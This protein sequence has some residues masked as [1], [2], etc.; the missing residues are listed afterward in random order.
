[1]HSFLPL[2]ILIGLSPLLLLEGMKLWAL[3]HFQFFPIAVA[4]CLW[5]LFG[6]RSPVAVT[7]SADSSA[8][9]E[10]GI[11]LT[12]Y[13]WWAGTLCIVAGGLAGIT[14][15]WIFSPLMAHGA[16]IAV[17][18]G[19]CLHHLT[20][21]S[22]WRIAGIF[23]LLILCVPLP[24]GYDA[25][26]IQTLQSASSVA[27]GN[28]LD[29][30][31]VIHLREG[32]VIELASKRLFVEE[33]CSGVDSLYALAAVALAM[34]IYQRT[35]L[36]ASLCTMMTVPFWATMGNLFRLVTIAIGVEKWSVD[37][38][39]GTPHLILGL[40][41]FL[42]VS[43][44]HLSTASAFSLLFPPSRNGEAEKSL[45]YPCDL[46]SLF[47][48]S[49]LARSISLVLVPMLG[50]GCVLLGLLAWTVLPW[51]FPDVAPSWFMSRELADSLPGRTALP[52]D[53]SN[54]IAVSYNEE[55]REA[56]STFG[57][58]SHTWRYNDRTTTPI[59]S[60]DFPFFAW[61]DVSFCYRLT[62][63]QIL[64]ERH[65]VVDIAER[66][67]PS[68]KE[69]FLSRPDGANGYVIF[70]HFDLDGRYFSIPVKNSYKPIN[71]WT[72]LTEPR[73]EIPVSPTYFQFQLFVESD[74][75]LT[76]VQVLAYRQMYFDALQR[77]KDAARPALA[78]IK[79]LR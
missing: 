15:L 61:H 69:F 76:D 38:S 48:E 16:A 9:T 25:K 7:T 21:K 52:T 72:R 4:F 18:L 30:F 68:H 8:S 36:T 42:L 6:D 56:L 46:A 31:G 73:K 49:I 32:N 23:S 78:N 60:L 54:A 66:G 26:L 34:L 17:F 5:Q 13:R 71:L 58:Y 64:R 28:V 77:V 33:A 27:C 50:I 44:C 67:D 1:M 57:R 2:A 10:V 63:W 70:C 29:K 11:R 62:G 59:L 40:I 53:F 14:A 39:T 20:D 74:E 37:L 41:V 12:R 75:P 51:A 55:E 43:A 65:L 47:R 22:P 45:T 79:E 3:P 24:F 19:W 35:S